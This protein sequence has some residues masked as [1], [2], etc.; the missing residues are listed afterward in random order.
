MV[1]QASSVTV[2][3]MEAFETCACVCRMVHGET[4]IRNYLCDADTIIVKIW[5]NIIISPF[6]M[7]HSEGHLTYPGA[8]W[9]RVRRF[10]S[11]EPGCWAA[12]QHIREIRICDDNFFLPPAR[13]Q[14]TLWLAIWTISCMRSP[15]GL[16]VQLNIMFFVFANLTNVR[17]SLSLVLTP[18]IGDALLLRWRRR[19][20]NGTIR[21]KVDSMRTARTFMPLMIMTETFPEDFLFDY[22]FHNFYDGRRM[23]RWMR[24]RSHSTIDDKCLVDFRIEKCHKEKFETWL[25][26]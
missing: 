8:H 3:V 20:R 25:F 4:D 2:Y 22:L 10:S 7:R 15:R 19:N 23:N 12:E 17:T 6:Y 21:V 16:L 5:I 1:S 11:V 9:I 18:R 26:N 14:I 13:P 24:G